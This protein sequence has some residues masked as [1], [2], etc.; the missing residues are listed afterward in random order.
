MTVKLV[1][2]NGEQIAYEREQGAFSARLRREGRCHACDRLGAECMDGDLP[3]CHDCA[4]DSGKAC[5]IC[6]TLNP[7]HERWGG[8]A[9]CGDCQS[10]S[11][12][13]PDP[14]PAA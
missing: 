10:A 14:R 9:I 2:C 4:T 11:V 3:I 7:Q 13:D 5:F 6:G 1:Y 12:A 8:L